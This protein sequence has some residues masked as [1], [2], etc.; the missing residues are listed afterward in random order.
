MYLIRFE[1]KLLL[2]FFLLLLPLEGLAED[3]TEP[4]LVEWQILTNEVDT[5][6][7]SA[8]VRVEFRITDNDSGVKT[9]NVT[10]NS[11][12]TDQRSDGFAAVSLI[13]GDRNDGVWSAAI[14]IPKGSASGVWE[15]LLFPLEDNQGNSGSFEIGRA[16]V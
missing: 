2:S 8:T 12:T 6:D 16:H 4:Q 1:K 11:T 7:T 13:S 9:P 10:A 3:I 14:S 15:V 5:S